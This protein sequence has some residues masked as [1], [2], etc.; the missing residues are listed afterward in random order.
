MLNRA[1]GLRAQLM[2]LLE[3]SEP[4]EKLATSS[5]GTQVAVVCVKVTLF[6][7]QPSDPSREVSCSTS[8]MWIMSP[9]PYGRRARIKRSPS[10]YFELALPI[11]KANA[12]ITLLRERNSANGSLQ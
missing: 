7:I 12:K 11:M 1:F 6:T 4:L 9:M 8:L 2:I 3:L 10:K 5:V